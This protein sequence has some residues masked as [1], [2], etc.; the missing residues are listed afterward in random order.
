[1]IQ[2]TQ[3]LKLTFGVTFCKST[4]CGNLHEKKKDLCQTFQDEKEN[5]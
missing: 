2:M 5:E 1:M 3:K 4:L